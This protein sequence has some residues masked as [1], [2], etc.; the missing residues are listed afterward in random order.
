MLSADKYTLVHGVAT[1]PL[2]SHICFIHLCRLS[3]LL[4]LACSINSWHFIPTER[5]LTYPSSPG[6]YHYPSLTPSCLRGPGSG[7]LRSPIYITG[8]E[9]S[10]R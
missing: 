5:S 3:L 9:D 4:N 8:Q 2:H 1:F 10:D 6:A 7:N